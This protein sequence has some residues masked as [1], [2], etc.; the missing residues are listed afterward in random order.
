MDF[1]NGGFKRNKENPLSCD[2]LIIDEA[3]MIDTLLFYHLL[4]AIPTT[5]RLIVIGDTDQL[6]SVGAGTVLKDLIASGTLGVTRLTQIYRQAAHSKIVTNAHLINQGEFPE[7][8]GGSDF[9][10]IEHESPEEILQTI[11]ELITVRIP[12]NFRLHRLH[13]IQVLAPIN[14]D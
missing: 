11:V 8:K 14:G 2:L 13:D 6:P 5:A 9:K 7:L 1:Q 4:K 3:S 10:F 12:A